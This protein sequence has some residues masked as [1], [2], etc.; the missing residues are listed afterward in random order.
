MRTNAEVER[1]TYNAT[2]RRIKILARHLCEYLRVEKAMCCCCKPCALLT[3]DTLVKVI[4]RF[5][6]RGLK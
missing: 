4:E 5:L 2:D 6:D 1:H 3:D